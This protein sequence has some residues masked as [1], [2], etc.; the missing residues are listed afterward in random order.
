MNERQ[1]EVIKFNLTEE[2][3]VLERL[4]KI[5]MDSALECSLQIKHLEDRKDLVNI[6]SI[7][8]QKTYQEV[9]SKNRA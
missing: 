2:Q 4:K 9:Q 1:K 5:Y 6:Q 3:K 7:V 8:Y